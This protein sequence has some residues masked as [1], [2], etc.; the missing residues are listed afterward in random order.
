MA[1]LQEHIF[2]E[3]LCKSLGEIPSEVTNIDMNVSANGLTYFTIT[4]RIQG[5]NLVPIYNTIHKY[6]WKERGNETE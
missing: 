3:E 2:A 4:R 6:L 5:N 1:T